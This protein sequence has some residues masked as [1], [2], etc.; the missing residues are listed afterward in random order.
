MTKQIILK[1]TGEII[2]FTSTDLPMLIHGAHHA[3][4]SLFSVSVIANLFLSGEKILF[5]TA[6]HMAKEEF[7]EQIKGSEKDIFYVGGPSGI[8]Q[9]ANFQAIIVKSGDYDLCFQVAKTLPDISDRVI[10]VKNI[11]SIL[12]KEIFDEIKKYPKIVLSGDLDGV[13]FKDRF[14]NLPFQTKILFSNSSVDL[15]VT[16]PEL[17]K[18]TGYMYGLEKGL[19]TLQT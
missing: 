13:A 1:E 9:A 7:T 5:F 14:A 19:V 4:A 12:T 16:I 10:F 3:G 11:E 18:Y 8:E 6:Y 2:N 15:G 17:E